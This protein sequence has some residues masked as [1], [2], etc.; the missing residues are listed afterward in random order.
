MAREEDARMVVGRI[1]G[2]W[3][4]AHWEDLGRQAEM[5]EP[6]FTVHGWGV[7]RGHLDREEITDDWELI[8]ESE[9]G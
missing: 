7:D 2:D 1:S 5:T 3:C 9:G 8:A 4:I 6:R